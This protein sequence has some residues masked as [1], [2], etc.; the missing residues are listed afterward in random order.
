MPTPSRRRRIWTTI[1]A[2]WRYTKLGLG[3]SLVVLLLVLAVQNANVVHVQLLAWQ[4]DVSL[5]LVVIF[6]LLSGALFGMAISSWRR[7]RSRR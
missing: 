3:I 4:A 1:A 5:A 6:A 7:R 2:V